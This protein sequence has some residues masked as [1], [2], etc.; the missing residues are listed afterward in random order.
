M[1]EGAKNS[2]MDLPA[3]AMKMM[4]G[5][6]IERIAKLAKEMFPQELVIEINKELQKIKK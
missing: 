3:G 2:G 4:M 1:M 5:F 6:S